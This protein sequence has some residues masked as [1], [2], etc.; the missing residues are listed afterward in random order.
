MEPAKRVIHHVGVSQRGTIMSALAPSD[1][2]SAT[3]FEQY[4]RTAQFVPFMRD[5]LRVIEEELGLTSYHLR[6]LPWPG[7][8]TDLPAA[9]S[10]DE[11]LALFL[12][13]EDCRPVCQAAAAAGFFVYVAGTNAVVRFIP[14]M[15]NADDLDAPIIYQDASGKHVEVPGL[16]LRS[17]LLRGE[18][19]EAL[20]RCSL[21]FQGRSCYVVVMAPNSRASRCALKNDEVVRRQ[22]ELDDE[23]LATFWQV[24]AEMAQSHGGFDEMHLN[25]G[26][27][28]NVAHM[29]LKVWIDLAKFEALWSGQDV[30]QRLY[31]EQ[32]KREKPRKSSAQVREAPAEQP[33]EIDEELAAAIAMSLETGS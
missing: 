10:G 21:D 1:N 22:S 28:Q 18:E 25:A 27:F 12:L 13:T 8:A 9:V 17:C 19:P 23:E 7:G 33:E 30:Y 4:V 26:N 16:T 29:H 20:V 15:A 3:C 2:A 6:L 5:V 11:A 14:A 32:K 24:G 31:A